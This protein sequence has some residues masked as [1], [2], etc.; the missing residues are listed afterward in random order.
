MAAKSHD[1]VANGVLESQDDTYGDNHHSQ[2]DSHTDGGYTNSRAAHFTFVALVAI[3]PL[4][5]V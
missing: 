2:S 5:Y 1:F 3:Y 4:G